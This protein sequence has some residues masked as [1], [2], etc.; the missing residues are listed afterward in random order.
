MAA[1]LGTVSVIL[2]TD[3]SKLN[4][5]LNKA[6][7]DIKNH[8]KKNEGLWDMFKKTGEKLGLGFV[9]GIGFAIGNSLVKV[10]GEVFSKGLERLPQIARVGEISKAFSVPIEKFSQLQGAAQAS[11]SDLRD[12]QEA[13]TTVGKAGYSAALGSAET[14]KAFKDLKI[15]I[16]KFN[17]L[18]VVDKF[19]KLND[20]L[21]TVDATARTT[22]VA[23]M[24]GED[25][26]KNLA[27]LL[28]K[29]SEEIK[30]L[31]QNYKM[32]ASDVATASMASEAFSLAQASIQKA[33][34]KVLIA[35]APVF[36]MLARMLPPVIDFL[37]KKFSGAETYVVPVFKTITKAISGVWDVLKI[38]TG[39][40]GIVAG[41]IATG[42]TI[43]LDMLT[44]VL[45]MLIINLP[46]NM[47]MK[48]MDDISSGIKTAR[49][50]IDFF[51]KKIDAF[52]QKTAGNGWMSLFGGLGSQAIDK[53]FEKFNVKREEEKK[54][55][56]DQL[57]TR[58]TPKPPQAA[59]D[60]S[61]TEA[62]VRGTSAAAN[63]ELTSKFQNTIKTDS[64]KQLAV[65]E[66]QLDYL[67]E[68]AEKKVQ[69][70]K[71]GVF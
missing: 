69:E 8:S 32:T 24:L 39:I 71:L 9:T 30:A 59:I 5:G 66:K 41:Q 31:G 67:K 12:F 35:L 14:I 3:N 44:K 19:Y 36:E 11:G 45:D 55:R 6:E 25:S 52:S 1:N 62:A 20:A 47:R 51:A 23:Q 26:A 49:N 64:E 56:E 27:P 70:F 63:I 33:W 42:F 68:I 29:S 7:T 48:W 37:V 13:L 16:D 65:A 61:K 43:I 28:N 21:K 22:S 4:Q 46:A 17:K 54:N 40:V 38:G 2:A 53:F 10:M 57:N 34:D 18:D 15:D 60:L 50:E 58:G